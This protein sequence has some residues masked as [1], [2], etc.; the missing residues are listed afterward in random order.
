MSNVLVAGMYRSGSNHIS[1]SLAK[2][3]GSH[4]TYLNK[5]GEGYAQDAQRLDH[6]VADVLFNRLNG[7]VYLGHIMG[8]KYNLGVIRV[9][10]PRVIVTMRRLFPAL[11]SLRRYEEALVA[12]GRKDDRYINN[13]WPSF[14]NEQKWL[15]VAYNTIPWYYQHYVSWMKAELPHKMI[16]WYEEHFADQVASAKRMFEFLGVEGLT[17]ERIG[18][19][20][21]HFNSNYTKDRTVFEMP[22]FVREIARDQARGWGLWEER[23]VED[24]L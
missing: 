21:E 19:G 1:D 13:D 23:I 20:F 15:W 6:Q 24:L 22:K 8:T 17:D 10:E 3:L 12:D 9:F 11:H 2:T 16:V 5:A 4:R 18:K 7:M 14:T